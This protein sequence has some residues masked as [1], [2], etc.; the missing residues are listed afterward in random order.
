MGGL[1]PP[2]FYPRRGA[3]KVI[4]LKA[5]YGDK[6]QVLFL[7]ESILSQAIECWRGYIWP[8]SEKR[9]KAYCSTRLLSKRW[10]KEIYAGKWPKVKIVRWGEDG[11][12]V[13]FPIEDFDRVAKL[14][15]PKAKGPGARRGRAIK[16]IVCGFGQAGGARR[17]LAASLTPCGIVGIWRGS[18][19]GGC[20]RSE[21]TAPRGERRI[22]AYRY[23]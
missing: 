23:C 9:L 2:I 21:R 14:L 15:E 8:H 12:T 18:R 6:Y 10:T 7:E 22:T 5:K 1:R 16:K 17:T 4:D 19:V 3:V 11:L 13:T 20:L